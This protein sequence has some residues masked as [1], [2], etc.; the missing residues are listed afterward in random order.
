MAKALALGIAKSKTDAVQF[1]FSDPSDAACKS[2]DELISP[3]SPVQRANDNQSLIDA[4]EIVFLAVKPQFLESAL[5]GINFASQLVVS[6]AAGVQI[7]Q[8]ERITGTK[9]L[10]RV[11][12]NTPRQIRFWVWRQGCRG[13]SWACRHRRHS[14]RKSDGFGDWTFGFRTGLRLHVYRSLD[15]RGRHDWNG[16]RYRAWIGHSNRNWSGDDGRANGR[17]PCH[18]SGSRDQPRGNHDRCSQGTGGK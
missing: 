3:H 9:R 7:F 16:S 15:R 8:L 14:E 18:A 10:I 6:I 17:T 12:P 2:F 1:T 4:S 13:V 5:E 11:M